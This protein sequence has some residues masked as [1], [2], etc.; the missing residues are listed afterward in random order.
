MNNHDFCIISLFTFMPTNNSEIQIQA[1]KILDAIAIC[2][3][4]WN[5][6]SNRSSNWNGDRQFLVWKNKQVDAITAA[7]VKPGQVTV[8]TI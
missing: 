1:R 7:L 5:W 6:I 8:Y 4:C 3:C 2:S